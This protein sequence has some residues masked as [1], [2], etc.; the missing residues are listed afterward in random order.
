MKI[1]L[2]EIGL[3]HR[4]DRSGKRQEQVAGCCERYNELRFP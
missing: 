3:G 4:V 2:E 1:E